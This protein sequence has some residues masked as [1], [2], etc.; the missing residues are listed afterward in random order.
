MISRL[1][2]ILPFAFFFMSCSATIPPQ[3]IDLSNAISEEGRRMHDINVSLLNKL[4]EKKR[5]DIDTFIRD[6]YTPQYLEA[7][8]KKIPANID[9]EA[10]LPN[11]LKAITPELNSRRDMMQ[12]A[13]ENQRV[14]LV[15]KL[16]KDYYVYENASIRLRDLLISAVNL[17]KEEQILFE[18]V[19]GLSGDKIDFNKVEN[20]INDFIID[21]GDISNNILNLNNSIDELTK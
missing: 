16:E 5:E 21:G 20:A 8:N 4:F 13:L 14:K 19:N 3:S 1:K 10:E 7:F 9:Y 6:E 2:Y 15:T 11:I 17:D 12:S 18:Q